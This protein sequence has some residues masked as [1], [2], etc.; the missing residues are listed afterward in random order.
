MS[1][2]IVNIYTMRDQH[3]IANIYRIRRPNSSSFANEAVVADTN[4]T[5]M[6]KGQELTCDS[7]VCSDSN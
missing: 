4:L 5:A 6:C 7:G 2:R 1:I 3:A